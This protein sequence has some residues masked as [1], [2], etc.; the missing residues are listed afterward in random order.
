MQ[1]TMVRGRRVAGQT[2]RLSLGR[3]LAWGLAGGLAGTLVMDAAL[4][5][6]LAA[7]GL[8]PTTCFSIVGDTV[9]RF[10]LLGGL[11]LPGGVAMGIATHYVVGPAFGLI[12]GAAV[13]RVDALRISS[14]RRVVLLAVLCVEILSQPILATTPLLLGMTAGET[15][16]WFGLSFIMHFLLAVVLG[17]VVSRGLIPREE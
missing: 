10:F 8:P 7:A 16:Q 2:A 11:V 12:F 17:L 6:G 9:A 15:V 13:C 14:W 3:G 5:A 1:A 4:V